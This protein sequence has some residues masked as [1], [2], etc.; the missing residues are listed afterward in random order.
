MSVY[1]FVSNIT[2]TISVSTDVEADS[3]EA[4]MTIAAGRGFTSF[5]HQCGGE[6]E[7][8]WTTSGELDGDDPTGNV[9]EVMIDGE[10][11]PALLQLVHATWGSPGDKS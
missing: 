6:P 11:M 3:L 9:V 2:I 1:M 10:S 8:E 7:K 5:C 4:A